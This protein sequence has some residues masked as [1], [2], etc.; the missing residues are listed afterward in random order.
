[1]KA[2]LRFGGLVVAVAGLS[3]CSSWFGLF[4]DDGYFRDRG[5]DYRSAEVVKPLTVP[6][7]LSRDNLGQLYVIPG[8]AANAQALT[9]EKFEVPFPST[10]AAGTVAEAAGSVKL[11]KMG[12]SRWIGVSQNPAQAWSAAQAFL[13]GSGLGVGASN[14]AAGQLETNWLQDESQ[15]QSRDRFLVSVKSGLRPQSA[16]IFITHITV[17]ASAAEAGR[18]QWPAQSNNADREAWLLR[19]LSEYLANNQHVPM[20]VQ[21]AQI[22]AASRSWIDGASLVL[23]ATP[24][25]AW[26]AVDG[27]LAGAKLTVLNVEMAQ[28]WDVETAAPEVKPGFIKRVLGAD[29]TGKRYQLVF[30]RS[31][32]EQ[33]IGVQAEDGSDVSETE[34]RAL[35]SQVQANLQ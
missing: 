19:A 9:N 25:R 31:A 23:N 7:S 13:A 32:L 21:A 5:A 34:A 30:Y 29:S 15:P 11:Q 6:G 26:A 1:M 35:L 10:A 28:R 22:P 17:A 20:S 33:R 3:G 27:A 24:E 12:E 14:P 16:E 2:A 18:Y 4:G 8:G